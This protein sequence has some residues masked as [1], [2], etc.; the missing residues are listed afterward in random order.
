MQ[1]LTSQQRDEV[2]VAERGG[3]IDRL[4][5]SARAVMHKR[6]LAAVAPRADESIL[7]VGASADPA[8]KSSN[9]LEWASPELNITAAGLGRDGPAWQSAHPGV[10]YIHCSALELPFESG[11][12]D[13]V[14]SHAVIEH[15][16]SLDNQCRMVAEALRVARR[17]VWITTPNRWHPLEL[18][19]AL[20]LLHWLPKPAHRRLLSTLGLRHFASEEVLNLMDRRSL[21]AAA[22]RAASACPDKRFRCQ[23][24]SAPFL[25]APANLLLHLQRDQG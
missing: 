18:H 2:A 1:K 4:V 14:Y 9:Y 25:A 19:T 17:A 23:L 21:L 20:P 6:F 24:T 13:V 7:D 11:S 16:G 15:V 5:L 3:L 8:M 10:P 12:F 22:R